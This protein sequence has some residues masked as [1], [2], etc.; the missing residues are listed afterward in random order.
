MNS[1]VLNTYEQLKHKSSARIRQCTE[2]QW[3][4]TCTMPY[5]A[6]TL[7]SRQLTA[8]NSARNKFTD[9]QLAG[10]VRPPFSQDM[11]VQPDLLNFRSHA[12]WKSYTNGATTVLISFGHW[13]LPA[14]THSTSTGAS[15]HVKRI[16]LRTNRIRGGC[17]AMQGC[18]S[19]FTRRFES[20]W[21]TV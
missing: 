17:S 12:K 21:L 20:V 10:Q 9:A 13:T 18:F 7:D 3:E 4:R 1:K 19:G 6:R 15:I 5:R 16:F 14:S 11:H 2:R 8:E